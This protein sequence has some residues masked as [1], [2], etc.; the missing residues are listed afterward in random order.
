MSNEINCQRQRTPLQEFVSKA[1]TVFMRSPSRILQSKYAESYVSRIQYQSPLKS[2]TAPEPQQQQRKENSHGLTGSPMQWMSPVT[3]PPSFSRVPEYR[4]PFDANGTEHL[5]LEAFSPSVFSRVL[6]PSEDQDSNWRIEHVAL[7]NP[8]D[9]SPSLPHGHSHSVDP[10]IEAEAQEKILQFF[11]QKQIAPSPW[12]QPR[13]R[14]PP[15]SKTKTPA[16][17]LTEGYRLFIFFYTRIK[18]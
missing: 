3:P 7:L 10:N 17:V 1:E 5:H 9:F 2:V 8:T 13:S 4:N 12:S 14:F 16:Q 6:S 15:R 18:I 11:S